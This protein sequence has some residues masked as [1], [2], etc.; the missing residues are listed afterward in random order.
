MPVM[1]GLE[2]TKII[3]NELKLNIP[4]IALTGESSLETKKK[5]EAIGFDGFYTKPLRRIQL[6]DLVEKL[7]SLTA[8]PKTVGGSLDTLTKSNE[9]L[10]EENATNQ[11]FKI[12]KSN[13]LTP[14]SG[15]QQMIDVDKNALNRTV[16]PKFSVLIVED[17]NAAAKLLYMMLKN[18]DCVSTRAEN[19]KEALDI[20]RDALPGAFNLILMDLRMPVM[21]GLEATKI[22]KSEMK[23]KI[24]VIALTGES[25]LET[26]KKCEAIGFDGFYT[27]PLRRM[28]LKDLVEKLKSSAAY[29][30]TGGDSLFTRTN[31]SANKNRENESNQT[32]KRLNNDVLPPCSSDH[33]MVDVG[34]TG[35]IIAPV[36]QDIIHHN[37]KQKFSVLIVEDTNAAAKLL[38]MMLKKL[39]C[40]SI[41]AEN[42]KEALDILRDASPDKFDLILMDLRMPVM[43][44]LE[45]TKIIKSEMK[46]K[47]PVIAL[48]GE[49]S[50][51]TKKKCE[52][53]GFD[54]F[55]TK[56][57]RR[58]QL[59]DLVEKLKSSAAYLQTGGGSLD[60]HRE[61]CASTNRIN[62]SNQKRKL[63]CPDVGFSPIPKRMIASNGLKAMDKSSIL[64]VEDTDTAA[65]L[66]RMMLTKLN[67]S[68][69]RAE[70]GKRAIDI[71][72]DAIPGMYNLILMDLTMPVMD[73]MEATKIIKNSLKLNIPVVAVTGDTGLE[74]KKKC[75]EI[76]FD[77]FCT[78][79]LKLRDLNSI[80]AKHMVCC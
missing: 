51:E 79:P 2:A 80:I 59:K 70:N 15:D 67:C 24:P 58:M 11:N 34:E 43:D 23:L 8:N 17:T 22:I 10:N 6:K 37:A 27:K 47:I 74:T 54:G 14:S 33:Q 21:D 69:S 30:K 50:L 49:S 48:T 65:K 26:K 73:G 52:A 56:P 41:R 75:E 35:L 45:A 53:I 76:G 60:T 55:Y 63:S 3:K 4:V 71:L 39:D 38:C 1:D 31:L 78:K 25:S 20:L 12:L 66:I 36:K 19:G 18:N 46:L 42:G 68:S 64:V 16:A 5:C 32:W 7:N 44:G 72:R 13:A 40:S 9:S 57:L 61:I 29:L 77:G 28:Q 62:V